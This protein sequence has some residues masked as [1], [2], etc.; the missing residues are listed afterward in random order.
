MFTDD[1]TEYVSTSLPDHPNNIYI[2]DFNL[3]VSDGQDT[4]A[5]IFNDFIEAM[6]LYQH[7]HFQTHK[8]GNVLDLLLSDITQ[9][10]GVITVAPGPY[11]SDHWAVIATLNTKKL[12]IRPEVKHVRKLHKVTAEDWNQ[13][14]NTDN[15]P[16]SDNLE[17][18][19]AYLNKELVR[20]QDELAPVKKCTISLRPKKLWYDQE[21]KTLKRTMCKHEIKW[22]KYGLDSC[23][24]A[25]KVT[26]NCY[27]AKLN[28]KKQSVIKSNIQGCSKD[29]HKLHSLINNLTSPQLETQWSKHNNKQELADSF[30]QFFQN[31]ILQIRERF[32]DIPPFHAEPSGV[33]KISRFTPMTEDEVQ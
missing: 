13:A 25:Y 23:W 11:M 9:E 15:V 18:M 31:K 7:I 26:R 24:K 6:G 16:L 17:E 21:M 8:S 3:Y 33:P 20:V 12:Q 32:K 27:Y 30:T 22:I 10:A 4:D 1:F 14:Y 5:A 19:V 2:G 29:S 28:S